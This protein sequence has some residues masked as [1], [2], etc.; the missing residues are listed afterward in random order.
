MDSLSA[1]VPGGLMKQIQ[2]LRAKERGFGKGYW[3][4]NWLLLERLGVLAGPA[5]RQAH[6]QALEWHSL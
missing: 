1:G 4:Q 5:I 3:S 2:Q 6:T